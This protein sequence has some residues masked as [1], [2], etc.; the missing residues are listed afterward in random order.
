MYTH[1]HSAQ[2]RPV[3]RHRCVS[4]E[5]AEWQIC[6]VFAGKNSI[7]LHQCSSSSSS[8][9]MFNSIKFHTRNINVPVTCPVVAIELYQNFCTDFRE[10]RTPSFH[11]ISSNFNAEDDDRLIGCF[12][13]FWGS[14]VW[15]KQHRN[16][17][18]CCNASMHRRLFLFPGQWSLLVN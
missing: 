15:T 18:A 1:R 8:S 14:E 6:P 11:P 12:F 4:F 3:P 7:K 2:Y 5:A 9:S 13:T 16:S 10:D 17:C